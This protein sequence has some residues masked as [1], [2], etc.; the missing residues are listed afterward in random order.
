MNKKYLAMACALVCANFGAVAQAQENMYQLDTLVVTAARVPQTVRETPTTV[1]VVDSE[2][3]ARRE[4]VNLGEALEAMPGISFHQD[5]MT[6]SHVT[7]RGT[8]ARH[9][10]ILVD[11]KRLADDVSKT[12]ANPGVLESIGMENVARVEV[13]KGAASALYGSEAIGGVINIIT[14]RSEKPTLKLGGT[15]GN[16]SDGAHNQYH[17]HFSYDSGTVAP[18]SYRVS[19]GARKIVPHWND[20]EGTSYRFGIAR[21]LAVQLSYRLDPDHALTWDY[22][23]QKYDQKLVG[24]YEIKTKKRGPKVINVKVNKDD[25]YNTLKTRNTSLTYC[26]K[27]AGWEYMVRAYRNQFTKDY[28][29]K[30]KSAYTGADYAKH[31]E[32]VMEGQATRSIGEAHRFTLGTVFRDEKG[33]STR[34]K[35][36]HEAGAYQVGTLAPIPKYSDK[37]HYASAYLQDEYRPNDKW[38]LVPAL[39]FD[40]SDRFG[41]HISPKLGA[42]YFAN[43]NTRVKFNVGAG[44]VTPGLMELNYHFMMLQDR[45][46]GPKLGYVSFFWVGNEHLKPEKSMNYEL[47]MEKD[48]DRGEIKVSYFYNDIKDYIG[49]VRIK[50]EAGSRTIPK[51]GKVPTHKWYYQNQNLSKVHIQ[52]VEISGTQELGGA[53]ELRYGYTWL[54]AEDEKS[55]QR[56]ADRARHKFDLGVHYRRN[57]WSASFWGNYYVDYLDKLDL[58]E[59]DSPVEKNFSTFN[60]LVHYEVKPGMDIYAGVDNIFDSET[61]VRAYTGRFIKLGM[62]M[63]I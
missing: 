35:T 40:H 1:T 29:T 15:W 25:I 3:L 32:T 12:S 18:F 57:R 8:D 39:R 55:G 59:K 63:K 54:Q 46:M 21:P 50:D 33:I 30:L 27:D 48:F 23:Y 17:Y 6:R 13:V 9:T 19:Y 45:F 36:D 4:A 28:Y 60:L 38:L 61:T 41:S 49:S 51:M 2:E 5:S 52:G 56:L 62:E 16:F 31:T 43:D 44:Y 20:F 58:N 37:I 11:G 7:I 24:G 14:K 34:M 42:T 26:G 53:F 47:S 10:L 22:D